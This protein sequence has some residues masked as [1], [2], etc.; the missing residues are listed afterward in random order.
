MGC[1]LKPKIRP[2]E[3]DQFDDDRLQGRQ[4]MRLIKKILTKSKSKKRLVKAFI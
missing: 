1:L 2:S 4:S 3:K